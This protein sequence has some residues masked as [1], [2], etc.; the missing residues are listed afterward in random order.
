MLIRSSTRE[1]ERPWLYGLYCVGLLALL[2]AFFRGETGEGA[3]IYLILTANITVR[4]RCAK[5]SVTR[6]PS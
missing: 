4:A 5:P 3:V 2:L 6:P 1:G